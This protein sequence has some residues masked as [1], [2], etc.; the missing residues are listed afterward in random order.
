V[1]GVS[2]FTFVSAKEVYEKIGLSGADTVGHTWWKLLFSYI[3]EVV[4]G[5]LVANVCYNR[6]EI[7]H[8]YAA[9]LTIYLLSE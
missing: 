2:S 5:C 3:P 9:R 4:V 7:G 6:L 1:S 8:S